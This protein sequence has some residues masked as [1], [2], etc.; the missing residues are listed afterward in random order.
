MVFRNPFSR[1]SGN[2][3]QAKPEEAPPSVQ[4]LDASALD[5]CVGGRAATDGIGCYVQSEQ[6]RAYG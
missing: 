3:T 6:H 2:P 5:A 4:R 1:K